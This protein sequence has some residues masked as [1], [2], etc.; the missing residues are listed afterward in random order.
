MRG[1]RAL[2]LAVLGIVV[3]VT[4]TVDA[5]LSVPPVGVV[6]GA[7]R[8][9]EESFT[10]SKT[11]LDVPYGRAV[12]SRGEEQTL[13]LDVYEPDGDPEEF[14]PAIVW[15]HGGF[16]VAGSK[17]EIGFLHELTR[18]GYVTISINYRLRPE[19]PPFNAS[20]VTPEAPQNVQSL[21]G[22]V[23][24]AQHDA[25]A[26][27]R[28]VRANAADL[29]VDP[30]R[31][32]I[33]GFSAGGVTAFG[34]TFNPENDGNSGNPGWPSRVAAAISQ[35]GGSAIRLPPGSRPPRPGDAPILALHAVGDTTVPWPTSV[36]A[37]M[38]TIAVGNVCEMR[39]YAQAGHGT[40]H[41]DSGATSAS[42][43]HR[44]VIGAA[45]VA[46]TFVDVASSARGETVTATGRLT[47][48]RGDPV[49]GARILGRAASGWI[50]TTSGDAGD[51]TLTIPTP[52]HGR[53]VEVELRYEGHY[54]GDSGLPVTPHALAPTPLAPTSASVTAT[55][56]GGPSVP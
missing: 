45:R 30:A 53:S 49:A 40:P 12:N 23:A 37:C 9:L 42:F 29:R 6:P 31:V 52:D 13:T 27:I 24:D 8:Y 55:W 51:F 14:R 11:Q 26:A 32:M 10:F 44:H 2:S 20:F 3:A 4:P 50:E 19:M 1:T 36:P 38:L 46:T 5:Q 7:G 18:R 22:A 33:A 28:W 25:Q 17:A 56:G 48:E 35:S 16:F 39:W 21:L 47:T 15:L 34:A 43:L 41:D 54:T